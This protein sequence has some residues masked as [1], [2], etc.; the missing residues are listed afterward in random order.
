[1]MNGPN[2]LTL[3]LARDR[4]RRRELSARELTEAH[5]AA[6]EAASALNAYVTVSAEKARAMAE[7]S[8]ERLARGEGGPLE[9]LPLGIKD[10]FCTRAIPTS[11][12]SRILGG[13]VPPYESTV[14]ARLWA[15]GAV[16]L[17]KLN[18]DEFA[19]GSSNETS[20]HGG[21]VN[22]WTR[23]TSSWAW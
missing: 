16:C 19:M 14:T 8:D 2:H 5:L 3:A 1:M 10:L 18:L 6:I 20:C 12:G 23:Q 13:F 7:A 17:G 4:L 9:G 22:P 15:A 11:A 21:V